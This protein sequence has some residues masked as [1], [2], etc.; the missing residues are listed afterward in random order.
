MASLVGKAPFAINTAD[1]H[2]F[3]R[4]V[5][6]T[7]G[8]RAGKHR[9]DMRR[10][11]KKQSAWIW[12]W[13]HGPQ[14][15][16]DDGGEGLHLHVLTA[17]ASRRTAGLH[18]EIAP[19]EVLETACG[20][21]ALGGKTGDDLP[22]LELLARA[23]MP[24]FGQPSQHLWPPAGQTG[25]PPYE[26]RFEVLTAKVCLRWFCHPTSVKLLFRLDSSLCS[27]SAFAW[28]HWC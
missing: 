20:V 17:L 21:Q 22:V 12:G 1:G 16:A 6:Q 26:D 15:M 7:L 9:P 23:L 3:R 28:R 19:D 11:A 27:T 2:P 18:S 4:V 5:M 14:G 10:P 13:C 24:A 25:K 8:I